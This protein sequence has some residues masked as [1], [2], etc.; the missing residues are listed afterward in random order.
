MKIDFKY[1]VEE[2]GFKNLKLLKEK[3]TYPYECMNSFEMFNEEK[4]RARKYFYSSFS[5]MEK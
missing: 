3:G 2:L 1:L 4:L 5:K